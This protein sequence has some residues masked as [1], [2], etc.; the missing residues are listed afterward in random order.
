MLAASTHPPI[1]PVLPNPDRGL[2]G[3]SCCAAQAADRQLAGVTKPVAPRGWELLSTDDNHRHQQESGVATADAEPAAATAQPRNR[4]AVD[5]QPDAAEAAVEALD[6][7]DSRPQPSSIPNGIAA[8]AGHGGTAEQGTAAD[9]GA[10]ESQT[11]ES[12][13]AEGDVHTA[14]AEHR[15]QDALIW[16][17][18]E[19]TGEGFRPASG[20]GCCCAASPTSGKHRGLPQHE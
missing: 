15:M 11:T 12:T 5:G 14:S 4:A 16:I 19:M 10:P 13:G 9:G 18:L 7:H 2:Q 20:L 8:T 6:T 17:D 3:V 1:Q